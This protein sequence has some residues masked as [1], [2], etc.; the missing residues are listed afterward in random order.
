MGKRNNES[1]LTDVE[2]QFCV[3]YVKRLSNGTQAYLAVNPNV[4]ENSAAAIASKLLKNIN[5][6]NRIKQLK[7][8]LKENQKI[9]LSQLVN[10]LANVY[11]ACMK[12]RKVTR[13]DKKEKKLI[14]TGEIIVDSKGAND[15]IKIM[16]NLLG[17]DGKNEKAQE[18]TENVVIVDDIK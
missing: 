17:L 7:D 10:S 12:G 18:Q 5:I 6:Q 8:E 3:E 14:E 16:A 15:A 1:G 9:D 2:E 11:Q 4:S 13:W